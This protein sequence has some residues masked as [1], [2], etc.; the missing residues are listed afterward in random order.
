VLSTNRD[1]DPDSLPDDVATLKA[2][3]IAAHAA[4][5]AAEV[6]ARSD[7]PFWPLFSSLRNTPPVLTTH[8]PLELLG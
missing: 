8:P 5:P 7:S 4:C 6:R 3:V 1:T 2:R